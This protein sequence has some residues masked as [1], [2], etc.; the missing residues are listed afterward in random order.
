MVRRSLE[1]AGTPLAS[2]R[3]FSKLH[4][5]G[6][7]MAA[8][9]RAHAFDFLLE[10]PAPRSGDDAGSLAVSLPEDSRAALAHLTSVLS[11]SGMQAIAVDRTTAELAAAGLTA[12]SVSIPG[13]QPTSML[14]FGQFRG[15]DRLRRGPAAMGQ[16]HLPEE[17]MNPWPQPFV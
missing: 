16:R 4:D 15:H 9:E 3:D 7:Y 11:A 10:R 13:L 2:V 5:G 17:K 14:P 1:A 6:H 8:R 12:V